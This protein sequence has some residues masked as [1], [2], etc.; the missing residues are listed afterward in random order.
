MSLLP[1]S[2]ASGIENGKYDYYFALKGESA[3]N[4]S[5]FPAV[6]DIQADGHGITGLVYV[7]VDGQVLDADQN[8]LYLNGQPLAT[9]NNL[10]NIGDWSQ[11]AAIQDVDMNSNITGAPFGIT[12]SKY[13]GYS[14]G[15]TLGITG[16]VGNATLLLDNVAIGGTGFTGSAKYWSNF[17]AINSVN[18][19]GNNIT[20]A[21]TITGNSLN[22]NT[23]VSSPNATFTN[24][25]ITN[26]NVSGITGI[27]GVSQWSNYNAVSS[28]KTNGNDI[29][30]GAGNGQ[31][32]I[33]DGD[34]TLA[35]SGGII[36]LNPGYQAGVL[37]RGV[38]ANAGRVDLLADQGLLATQYS[39]INITAQNGN[40][41]RIN[42]V[43]NAGFNG[44]LPFP[45]EINLTAN[46]G[47]Y[48]S[49]SVGG[50]ININANTP[51]STYPATSAIK[52]NAAG[53]NL[54]AGFQSSVGSL[55]GY[56]FLAAKAGMNIVSSVL[57]PSTNFPGSVYL[58]G[59]TGV[60][61]GSSMYVYNMIT[62]YWNGTTNPQTLLI[63][64]RK[65]VGVDFPVDLDLI[66]SITFSDQI[67]N[68]AAIYKC[69]KFIGSSCTM[70]GITS[71]TITTTN[72][73]TLQSATGS[74]AI[75]QVGSI[76]GNAGSTISG[77]N[78]TTS[79]TIN[80]NQLNSATGTL[81][82]SQVGT[83]TGNTGSGIT[84]FTNVNAING[85]FT[86]INNIPA[87]DVVSPC[88]VLNG[89][90]GIIALATGPTQ[91]FVSSPLTWNWNN[92]PK[93]GASVSVA[94]GV[95]TAGSYAIASQ[96]LVAGTTYYD[97]NTYTLSSPFIVTSSSF[98]GVNSVCATL[99]DSFNNTITNG[100][101][102]QVVV[103][104]IAGA[105]TP[106]TTT[107]KVSVNMTSG[108][109]M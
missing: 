36:N 106:N 48:G 51:L 88:K 9:I 19:G 54:Y 15:S 60:V 85:N 5:K 6:S 100:A 47:T 21:L 43:S 34:I 107:G 101:S 72:T 14:Q 22:A 39:D 74:L 25:T 82:I 2:I 12:G 63:T 67:Q 105:G 96:I 40:R 24:A 11:Y 28:V 80:T 70:S 71:A 31:N 66:G 49:S 46:G 76:T 108:Q 1:T 104:V 52:L 32:I 89:T 50:V 79:S 109:A 4:W 27:T 103:Y 83:M 7:N 90:F 91:V 37:R 42:L 26:L 45:G 29:N 69:N 10:P 18:M 20:N 73:N 23:L 56:M 3:K 38:Y 86:N 65:I 55:A 44:S 84:G 78:S 17:P 102:Y 92:V 93:L 58:Y 94:F 99:T 77:I 13:Y 61:V 87:Y 30:A 98:Q 57:P 59:D 8:T 35:T 81:N 62:N 68:P 75:S 53:I 95:N 41:G 64:G 16:P 97:F 33:A